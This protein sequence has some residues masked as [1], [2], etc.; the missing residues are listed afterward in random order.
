MGNEF[1][2][3]IKTAAIEAARDGIKDQFSEP[4]GGENG[5]DLSTE[6]LERAK[7]ALTK[8]DAEEAAHQLLREVNFCGRAHGLANT[9]NMLTAEEG[10][11][12]LAHGEPLS[13]V[14]ERIEQT[15]KNPFS[16]RWLA[17]DPKLESRL[18][19]GLNNDRN[20][21]FDGAYTKRRLLH[22]AVCLEIGTTNNAALAKDGKLLAFYDLSMVDRGIKYHWRD[23][24]QTGFNEASQ[25]VPILKKAGADTTY[26]EFKL[27]QFRKKIDP[28]LLKMPWVE[29]L[30]NVHGIEPGKSAFQH[31]MH[32]WKPVPGK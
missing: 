18:I 10:L 26:I 25:L 1:F 6:I 31:I 20:Y 30:P 3:Q 32:P 16:S 14:K 11:L 7:T 28:V 21:D 8:N 29:T 4:F 24:Q 17:A 15:S 23:D 5:Y 27:N 9:K 19:D 22:K 13:K 2:K 12:S